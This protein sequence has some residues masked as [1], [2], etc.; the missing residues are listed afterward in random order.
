MTMTEAVNFCETH[1]CDECPAVDKRTEYQKKVLHY[2]CCW[3][4]ADGEEKQNDR[5]KMLLR[6]MQERN[7]TTLQCIH[8]THAY[9]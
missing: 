5:K 1:D 9:V 7:K 3:N 2:P 8:T 4:L 6:Q